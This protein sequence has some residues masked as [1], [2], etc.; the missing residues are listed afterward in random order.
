[1]QPEVRATAVVGPDAVPVKA[2]AIT[3][4]AARLAELAKH[5]HTV[6]GLRRAIVTLAVIGGARNRQ[7]ASARF[8]GLAAVSRVDDEVCA[9]AM[10]DPDATAVIIPTVAF[11]AMGIA[12][13]PY[14]RYAASRVH[15][16]IVALAI[17]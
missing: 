14:Q 10:V 5:A 11:F 15:V 6:A 17:V 12:P 7:T 8:G 16:A 9:A 13:L 1:M 2:P 3:L 4:G